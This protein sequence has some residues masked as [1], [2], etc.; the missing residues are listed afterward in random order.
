[1]KKLILTSAVIVGAALGAYA[2]GVV[3]FNDESTPGYVIEST[4]SHTSSTVTTAY[5]ASPNFTA[6][7]YALSG[8]V[9][10]LAGLGVDA[11]GYITP[12]QF[13][14][15]G[16]N[17]VSTALGGSANGVTF[18]GGDG[19]FDGAAPIISGTTGGF[20][21]S[22]YTQNDVLAV[23]AWTGT[24]A[25]LATAL[26]NNAKVG[27]MAFVNNIGPGGTDPNIPNLTGWPSAVS[28][29]AVA[30]SD[31]FPELILSPVP[32]PSTLVL[33]TLGALSFLAIRRRK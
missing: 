4:L 5:V 31:N 29:L 9:T 10:S 14:L 19:Y 13:A 22:I 33:G 6:A 11:Y 23:V 12:G 15:D 25:N 1:M 27:I 28:P 18:F 32:E 3:A 7:L 26:A 17:L 20:N 21:G 16:F 8:H 2:Q 24:Y 30:N